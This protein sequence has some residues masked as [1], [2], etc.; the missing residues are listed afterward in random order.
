[1]EPGTG[2]QRAGRGFAALPGLDLRTREALQLGLEPTE[3]YW[4][5][6]LDPQGRA[7]SDHEMLAVDVAF[8]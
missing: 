7:I 3:I 4:A 6:A 1:M 8:E 2:V 5:D